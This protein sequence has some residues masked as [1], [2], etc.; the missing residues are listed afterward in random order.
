MCWSLLGWWSQ[1]TTTCFRR[2]EITQHFG[3]G[4]VNFGSHCVFDGGFLYWREDCFFLANCDF[5]FVLS[6]S[7]YLHQNAHLS[8]IM[9]PT[10]QLTDLVRIFG[11]NFRFWYWWNVGKESRHSRVARWVSATP[12]SGAKVSLVRAPRSARRRWLEN[13]VQKRDDI[14]RGKKNR[15]L[16]CFFPI[17]HHIQ[18]KCCLSMFILCLSPDISIYIHLGYDDIYI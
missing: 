16:L 18:K 10:L 17:S 11:V 7:I 8:P 12:V 13:P 6:R 3:S 1:M 9:T 14:D 4:F 15:V 2:V 5:E